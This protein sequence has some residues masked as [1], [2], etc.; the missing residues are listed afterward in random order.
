MWKKTIEVVKINDFEINDYVLIKF[1][2]KKQQF[3]CFG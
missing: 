3:Y 1:A 2:S